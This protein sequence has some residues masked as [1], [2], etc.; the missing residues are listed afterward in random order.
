[1]APR[2]PSL[3]A[4]AAALIA[5]AAHAQSGPGAECV[6]DLEALAP[7][8]LAN[9]AGARDHVA[10]KGQAMFDAALATARTQARSAAGD[11]ACLEALRA[12]LRT[13]RKTHLSLRPLAPVASTPASQPAMPSFRILS[14]RTALLVVPS[15]A[16]QA[17]AGLAALL[18]DHGQEIAQRPNLLVDV[19]GN[20]G[21]SDWTYAPLLALAD[22]NIRRDVGAQLFA[23]P[24]N[25]AANRIACDVFAPQSQ[26]CRDTLRRAA[27]AMER[28]A[29]GTF[30][31]QP[32]EPAVEIV[33]PR[34]VLPQ[35][36]RIGVLVD[37]GCGS[38]CEEFLLA[39]RQSF[40]VKLFG[41]SSTGSLDYSNLRPWVLP[42]GKRRLMYATS[43][44]LRLPAFAV[45]AAGIPPDQVLAA[46]RDD[47]ERER[48]LA[49]VQQVLES[50]R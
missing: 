37:S 43:R 45:D 8:M 9:D 12:Y 32:G 50:G 21:G 25:A 40:K 17:G 2:Q 41:Q 38:S 13:F 24:A 46:P 44:S 11:D 30:I 26:Q 19:R 3:L 47:A 10:Q 28:A 49:Q 7:Y 6:A 48:E 22:A 15:F 16:D 1:M 39:M 14:A 5:G 27:D 29:P 34:Q 35:P 42:S 33:V 36:S 20:G 31:A 23:T 4:L 18:K